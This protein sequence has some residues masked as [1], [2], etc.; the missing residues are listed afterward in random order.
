MSRP[1]I[2][3]VEDD[4]LVQRAWEAVFAGRGWNVSSWT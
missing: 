2:L 1:K 3:I 4:G